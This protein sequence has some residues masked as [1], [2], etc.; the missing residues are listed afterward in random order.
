MFD[1]SQAKNQGMR[2]V[3]LRFVALSKRDAADQHRSCEDCERQMLEGISSPTQAR[4][5]REHIHAVTVRLS[6]LLTDREDRRDLG[7]AILEHHY[8]RLIPRSHH[9][10][11]GQQ[12]KNTRLIP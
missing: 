11:D 8:T 12:C 2:R 5:Q 6:G 7:K 9:E 4:N 1:L 10:R 3:F